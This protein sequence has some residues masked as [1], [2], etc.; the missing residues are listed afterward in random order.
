MH[1]FF[2]CSDRSVGN[3]RS[4]VLSVVGV[5][6][7]LVIRI[8][9]NADVIYLMPYRLEVAHADYLVL[10][11]GDTPERNDRVRIV[12]A[13]DPV[14]S[15]PAGV[16]LPQRSIFLVEPVEVP[17]VLLQLAVR[18]ELHYLP[19]ELGLEVP[20]LVLG[21]FLP[22]EHELLSGVSGHIAEE[23]AHRVEAEFPR[24]AHL[25]EHGALSVHHL[26]MRYRK[27]VVLGERIVERERNEI[28]IIGS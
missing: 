1:R 13:G 9:R 6:N 14:E 17:D 16:A 26:V 27:Y 15:L 28:V 12:L 5:E 8:I 24:T 18:L 20:L 2:L 3:A 23:R 11:A 25:V 4:A 19:V 10:I 7:L 21:E 22:H